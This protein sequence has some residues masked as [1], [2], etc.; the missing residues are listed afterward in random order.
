MCS[1]GTTPGFCVQELVRVTTVSQRYDRGRR[2]KGE[3]GP[4]GEVGGAGEVGG[5]GDGR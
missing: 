2:R 5:G 3:I 4:E 1:S